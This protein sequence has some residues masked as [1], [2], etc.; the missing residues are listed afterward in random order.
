MSVVVETQP[1]VSMIVA[2]SNQRVIGVNNTL[3][4]HLSDDLKRFKALTMGKP[5][6]MGRKTW[7]SI[8]RPLPGRVNIVISRQVGF[9]LAGAQVCSGPEVALERALQEAKAA[10]LDEVF[11]IGGDAVYK[12]MLRFTD[13]IYLTEVDISV[14][15]D[16]WFPELESKTWLEQDRQ[17]YPMKPEGQPGFCF[18]TYQRKHND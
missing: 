14:D 8:G 3:P 16:A 4:W 13:R 1:R 11:I 7:D 9:A 6:I 15:G 18:V 12:K 5:I 17:C 2:M 10:G